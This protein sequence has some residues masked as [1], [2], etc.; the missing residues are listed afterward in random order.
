MLEWA[1]I[2]KLASAADM[3]SHGAQASVPFVTIGPTGFAPALECIGLINLSSPTGNCHLAG[4]PV[5]VTLTVAH[6]EPSQVCVQHTSSGGNPP[7]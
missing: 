6:A 5:V 3:E 7:H 1:E 4:G 2:L